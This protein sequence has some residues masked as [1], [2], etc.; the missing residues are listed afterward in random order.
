[1]TPTLKTAF[2]AVF[3]ILYWLFGLTMI[4]SALV[5]VLAEPAGQF[6]ISADPAAGFVL[7]VVGTVFLFAC[8]RLGADTAGGQAFLYVAL[9][10]AL[11]FGI[12]ALFSLLAVGADLV[13]FGDGEPWDPARVLGPMVWLALFPAA[14]LYA[15]GREFIGNLTGA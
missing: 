14:G 3:G 13:L 5:P 6:M 7:C 2:A 1:M 8:R 9:G 4:L 11:I 15:W 12:V 10:L